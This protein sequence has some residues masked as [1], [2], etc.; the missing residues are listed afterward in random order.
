MW[1]VVL[2]GLGSSR[3]TVV[4]GAPFLPP[5]SRHT[6]RH[7]LATHGCGPSDT[8]EDRCGEKSST[9]QHLCAWPASPYIRAGQRRNGERGRIGLPAGSGGIFDV[10]FVVLEPSV[11]STH[12]HTQHSHR[13]QGQVSDLWWTFPASSVVLSAAHTCAPP[14]R[15][16][17]R[18]PHRVLPMVAV[19]GG[20]MLGSFVVAC[21][22][23]VCGSAGSCRHPRRCLFVVVGGV[24]GLVSVSPSLLGCLVLGSLGD[25]FR[26]MVKWVGAR[27]VF[28]ASTSWAL[29][30]LSSAARVSRLVPVNCGAP[31][32]RQNPPPVQVGCRLP[33]AARMIHGC[34][35]SVVTDCL[36]TI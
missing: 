21:L 9:A 13:S 31:V 19:Y 17:S 6:P 4:N 23:V 29:H 15:Q 27:C 30:V 24:S 34:V 16:A 25:T 32:R 22:V 18:S 8:N 14:R 10:M 1:T 28:S 35:F 5:G 7:L 36:Q 11:C 26:V 2:V 20:V 3:S 12:T 33:Q